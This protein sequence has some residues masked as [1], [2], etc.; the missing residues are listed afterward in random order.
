MICWPQPETSMT[1][2]P[3]VYISVL[4]WNAA[5]QTI[6]CLR[7]LEQLDYPHYRVIVVDNASRDSSPARI[8]AAFPQAAVVESGENRGYAGGHS[9]AVDLALRA[10][11]DLIWLL[12]NDLTVQPDTLRHLVAAYQQHGAAL[13]GSVPLA[14]AD[15]PLGSTP[16]IF[17]RKYL[18]AD[19]RQRL[20]VLRPFAAYADLFPGDTPRPVAALSGSSFMIPTA[21]IRRH[22][23]MDVSFFLYAEEVDYCFR[24]RA[25]GI[26]SII[27][28][29]SRVVHR[30]SQSFSLGDDLRAAAIYYRT[31][32]QLLFIRRHNHPFFVFWALVRNTLLLL[33]YPITRGRRGLADAR[34]MLR[35]M[36]DALR[37]RTGKTIAPEHLLDS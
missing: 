36:L 7:S 4:N 32:N 20:F 31:R 34:M 13:Y 35:A 16:V 12:N 22:G 21:V 37:G 29:A 2:H 18:R 14:A 28:P 26:P 15:Q 23:F 6:D 17:A 27:V 10:G 3:L 8:R 24:L 19:F 25:Q 1:E 5:Q 30:K 9:L 11:A 33:A